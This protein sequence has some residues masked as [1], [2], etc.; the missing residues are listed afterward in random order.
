MHWCCSSGCTFQKWGNVFQS[1]L[2]KLSELIILQCHF[3]WGCFASFHSRKSRQL[4]PPFSSF[5]LCQMLPSLCIFSS[6]QFV[7]LIKKMLLSALTR[8]ADSV[9]RCL[10][11]VK[12]KQK[13]VLWFLATCERKGGEEGDDV[14]LGGWIAFSPGPWPFSLRRWKH[15]VKF[16]GG[17]TTVV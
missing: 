2:P 1:S 10:A 17:K 8:A 9:S 12:T 7:K 3:K 5:D 16:L 15:S 14:S 4:C 6:A 13:Q 11:M